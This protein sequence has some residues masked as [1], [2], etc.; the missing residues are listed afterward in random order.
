MMLYT[1]N[2]FDKKTTFFQLIFL[3]MTQ[4][5]DELLSD[6]F[7]NKVNLSMTFCSLDIISVCVVVCRTKMLF[8]GCILNERC[9]APYISD[10]K[11]NIKKFILWK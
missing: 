7:L 4:C 10:V 6:I 1:V 9:T 11:K 5:I 8:V 2:E 3:D